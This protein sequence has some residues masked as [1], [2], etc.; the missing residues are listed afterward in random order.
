M[1]EAPGGL[2]ET[3]LTS[4]LQQLIDQLPTDRLAAEVGSLANAESAD[5]V[6]RH[7]GRL[8][9]QAIES[10]PER[11]RAAR[12]VQL[13]AEVIGLL[14][15]LMD[16][17]DLGFAAEVPLAPGHVLQSILRLQPDG[18]REVVERPLTPLLDTTVLTNARGEP[19]VAHEI[20]AEIPSA[21]R[22]DVLMAFIRW[23]G[24]R[25]MADALRGHCASGP[26]G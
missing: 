21:D 18:S 7:I 8:L 2:Y 19:V 17:R 4:R 24:V 20:R 12:A 3:L 5:R 6:S 22:I 25:N 11:E 16:G 13:A 9:A 10:L 23:S 14:Q 15:M 26:V 1:T